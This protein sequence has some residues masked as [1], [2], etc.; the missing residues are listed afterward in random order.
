MKCRSLLAVATIAA[1]TLVCQSAAAFT[2]TI[3]VD[4]NGYGTFTNSTGFFSKLP[5]ALQNDPGPGGLANVLTYG[6]LDPPGLVAGDVKLAET[7][8]ILDVL[9]F[10]PS[11]TCVDGSTGCLAFY[12]DNLNGYDSLADTPAPPSAFYPNT[13]TIPEINNAYAIYTPIAGQPGFVA[14]AAGPVTYYFLSDVPEPASLALL[15]AG[16]AGMAGWRRKRSRQASS[17]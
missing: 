13:I 9:R 3:H 2:V 12:S 6:L 11:E 17:K 7:G 10:N 16:L 4:E 14:G 15:G 1:A 5:W 8:G